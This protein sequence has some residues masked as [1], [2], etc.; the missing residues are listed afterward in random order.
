[1][2]VM[3]WHIYNCEHYPLCWDNQALEFDT[4]E[5]AREFFAS[6]IAE[7]LLLDSIKDAVIVEDILDWD[8]GYINATNMRIIFDPEECD[9]QLR[10]KEDV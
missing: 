1:M 9:H 5:S 8:D 3:K 6:A 4:V 7:G 10:D 2:I